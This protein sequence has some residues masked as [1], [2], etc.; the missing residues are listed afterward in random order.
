LLETVNERHFHLQLGYQ[1]AAKYRRN[2][3]LRK[4]H[5]HFSVEGQPLPVCTSKVSVTR[6]VSAQGT[7]NIL[8][9]VLRSASG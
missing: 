6:L 5:A 7:I 8:G 2:K 1:R 3:R 4:L 9:R